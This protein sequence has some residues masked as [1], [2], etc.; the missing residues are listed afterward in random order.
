MSYV[1]TSNGYG[2]GHVV[3]RAYIG[4][5]KALDFCSPVSIAYDGRIVPSSP[6]TFESV[7]RARSY[8]KGNGVLVSNT[9]KIVA[10]NP[11]LNALER[12]VFEQ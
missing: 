2:T 1:I 8:I 3:S 11:C 4:K 12:E 9:W 10:Y 5:H 6:L 7:D